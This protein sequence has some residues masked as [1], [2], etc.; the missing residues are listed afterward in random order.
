MRTAYRVIA[1]LIA[2][3]VLVQ[4]ASIAYALFGLSA[5]VETGGVLDKAAMESETTDFSGVGGFPLHGINGQ[6]V[7]PLFVLVLLVVAFFAQVRGGLKWAG[8][9]VGL[10]VLQVLLGMLGRSLVG[11]GALH[12]LNALA[13]FVVA[14][15]AARVPGVERPGSGR[16][17]RLAEPA[18]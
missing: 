4:A 5:W 16:P 9:I 11:L 13:L 15:V 2:L 17:S 3:G 7:I 14:V 8:I 10:V 6:L 1:Y 12:G 18:A